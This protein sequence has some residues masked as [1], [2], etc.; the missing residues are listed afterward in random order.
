[1]ESL[2]H[3]PHIS[4]RQQLPQEIVDL[5]PPVALHLILIEHPRRDVIEQ[6]MQIYQRGITRQDLLYFPS[7]T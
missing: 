3:L 5:L 4:S 6:E 2:V 1:M 7:A